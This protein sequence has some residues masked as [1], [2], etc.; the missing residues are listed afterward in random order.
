MTTAQIELS[1]YNTSTEILMADGVFTTH[2]STVAE[3]NTLFFTVWQPGEELN[4]VSINNVLELHN[5]DKIDTVHIL[6]LDSSTFNIGTEEFKWKQIFGTDLIT[7][8]IQT[9]T[10]E[11]Y[12]G[13]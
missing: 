1:K 8:S 13:K 10:I 7:N 3:N 6:P 5:N 2:S 9:K 11:L 4:E 12:S